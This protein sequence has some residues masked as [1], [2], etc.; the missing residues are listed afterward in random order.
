MVYQAYIT[1]P[2][3]VKLEAMAQEAETAL[4]IMQEEINRREPGIQIAEP[5]IPEVQVCQIIYYIK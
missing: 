2:E 3:I 4:E 5:E 1:L